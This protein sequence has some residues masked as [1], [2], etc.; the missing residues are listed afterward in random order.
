MCSAAAAD[1]SAASAEIVHPC[2]NRPKR[3][4]LH[5]PHAE[6]HAPEILVANETLLF[7]SGNC[8]S[9]LLELGEQSQ[10]CMCSAAA[11]ASAPETAL[12]VSHH[13]PRHG[14]CVSEMQT[15]RLYL[16]PSVEPTASRIYARV[17]C[18]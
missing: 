9:V 5:E 16:F 7:L 3:Q 8:C 10:R 13:R 6:Y 18:F 1:T 14:D 12:V 17:P 2:P 15:G 11:D 4:A